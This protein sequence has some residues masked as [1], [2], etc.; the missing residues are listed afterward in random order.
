MLSAP[1]KAA[2]KAKLLTY[3]TANSLAVD[4]GDMKDYRPSPKVAWLR[5]RLDPGKTIPGPTQSGV[6]RGTLRGL[7]H[8]ECMTP[9]EAG[10]EAPNELA[11]AIADHFFPN[12]SEPQYLDTSASGFRTHLITPSVIEL[13]PFDTFNRAAA[14]VPYLAYVNQ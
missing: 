3:A 7:Y 8:I 12:W 10:D 2:F 11:D 9:T 1:L 4:W 6:H 13:P 14:L 5:P